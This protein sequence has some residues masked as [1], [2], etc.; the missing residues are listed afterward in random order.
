MTY[1]EKFNGTE[2]VVPVKSGDS[3]YILPVKDIEL[4]EVMC[5]EIT[6]TS[7][8]KQYITKGRLYKFLEKNNHENFIQVSKSCVINIKHLV[9]LETSFSG[10]MIAFMKSGKTV[11]VSRGF[12]SKLKQ[13]VNI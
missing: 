12:L 5:G 9:K 13:K 8:S 6:V 7:N 3:I 2:N 4:I 1:I 10:N 11:I